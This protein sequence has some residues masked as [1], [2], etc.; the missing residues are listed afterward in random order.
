MQNENGKFTN[1][2][3]TKNCRPLSS[4]ETPPCEANMQNENIEENIEEKSDPI[5]AGAPH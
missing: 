3:Q 1:R 5:R 2:F 4:K